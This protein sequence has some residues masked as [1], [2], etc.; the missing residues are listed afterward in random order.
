MESRIFLVLT[1]AVA[2]GATSALAEEATSTYQP[3]SPIANPITSPASMPVSGNNADPVVAALQ[4]CLPAMPIA[5]PMSDGGTAGSTQTQ[6]T[7]TNSC[8]FTNCEPPRAQLDIFILS[9]CDQYGYGSSQW[10]SCVEGSFLS[11]WYTLAS[12]FNGTQSEVQYFG[13]CENYNRVLGHDGLIVSQEWACLSGALNQ[14]GTQATV[15]VRNAIGGTGAPGLSAQGIIKVI[16]E[17][18]VSCSSGSGSSSSGGRPIIPPVWSF[19]GSSSSSSSS[20]GSGG[21][22]PPVCPAWGCNG[23]PPI[24]HFP[25]GVLTPTPTPIPTVCPAWGCNGPPPIEHP[26][27]IPTLTPIPVPTFTPIG[28]EPIWNPRPYPTYTPL[29]PQPGRRYDL[30]Q[31]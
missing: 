20:S 24:E 18:K 21:G 31:E 9:Q 7:G 12:Q 23:P 5:Q 29:E 19:P 6:G 3:I 26:F 28:P 8:P 14:V 1:V 13:G 2:L 30:Q 17:G 25:I 16:S 27:P 10:A 22:F 11:S 4:S 15:A